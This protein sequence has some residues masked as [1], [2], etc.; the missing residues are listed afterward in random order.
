MARHT[1]IDKHGSP[2]LHMLEIQLPSTPSSHLIRPVALAAALIFAS[3]GA[4]AQNTAGPAPLAQALPLDIPALPAPQAL[5]RLIASTQLQLIYAPDLVQGITTRA[6]K[7]SFTPKEA[8][9]RML[10]GTGLKSIETG[11]NAATIRP[12]SPAPERAGTADAVQSLDSVVVSATRRREPVRD[13]PMQVNVLGGEQLNRS[14]ARNLQDYLANEAGVDVKSTGGAGLGGLSMRGISTGNQTIATVGV[15]VDEVAFGS[16]TAFAGGPQMALDMAMLDL[17]HIELLRGPQ[18]TLYGAGAMG[19]LLKYVTNEPDTYEFSGKVSLGASA[20]KSG[21][22]GHTLGTVLNVPLKD[23]VAGLRISAFRDHAGG[24]IDAVGGMARRDIDRGDTTGARASLLLTP[25]NRFKMRFTATTQKIEREG[26]DFSDYDPATAR[27][28]R[29]EL[30]HTLSAGEPYHVKVDLVSADLEY[31]FGWARL[32]SITSRQRVRS[33]ITVDLSSA[34]VPL[35]AGMGMNL[36]STPASI[37]PGVDKT[38]QEF[39]LTS[40]ADKRFEWLLGLYIVRED[41]NNRQAV[42]S[43]LPGGSPGPQLLSV[44]M[45]AD[46]RELAA[47]G[48]LSW[49]FDN[50]LSLTGGLRVARNEQHYGQVIDGPLGGGAPSMNGQSKDRSTTWLL[51]ARY[52]LTPQS[53]VYARAATGYRPGG[54]NA[55]LYDLNTGK[56]TAPP[57]FRPDDLT[58]LEAGYKAD[59]LDKTLSL[60]GSVFDI[61][62]NDLQ[63]L[64]PVNGLSVIVNAGAARVRGA[65]LSLS[66]RPD[67]RWTL[68]GNVSLLDAKLSEDAPGLGGVDGDR[69][70]TSARFA[71]TFSAN[72][73]FALNGHPSYVGLT[74]RHVGNRQAGFPASTSVPLY[75]LPAYSMTDLQAGIDFKRFSLALFARNLFDK[76]AQIAAQSTVQALGG[77][78][79]VSVVRPRTLGATVT[80]P[81]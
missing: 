64:M 41:S 78:A 49:K 55:V 48:D 60:E 20:T 50:G 68:A 66:Y 9:T 5:Q 43:T 3:L 58:S 8:L 26:T 16:S 34:Y 70:P 52:P 23:D 65:E 1:S 12:S 40:R 33:L 67:E 15:Y 25:S 18:G 45:P 80:V 35:L 46:Y 32:N 28:V 69:L 75:K 37:T 21:G 6:I 79:W 77:P 73:A 2:L 54:P 11:P 13:V 53:S 74:Q 4:S 47:Y 51:T 59:L 81:F 30:E 22:S 7:G 72:Y 31:D 19:G 24:V 39:R 36:G 38:S 42:R 27:P 63:Q 57:T 44:E 61:R 56:P 14:G 17:N 29:G 71:A 10:E 76:R 62:W